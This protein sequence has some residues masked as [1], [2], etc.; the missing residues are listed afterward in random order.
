MAVLGNTTHWIRG[1]DVSILRIEATLILAK[2]SSS[3]GFAEAVSEPL[4]HSVNV[5]GATAMDHA[6]WCVATVTVRKS[7]RDPRGAYSLLKTTDINQRIVQ[8]FF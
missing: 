7:R 2:S 8:I 6:L 1:R 4:I 5:S 3:S